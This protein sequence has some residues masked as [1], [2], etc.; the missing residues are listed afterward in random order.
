MGEY[1]EYKGQ[2][3]KLGTCEDLYYT[4]LDQL[5]ELSGVLKT[6]GG[7][8]SIDEYLNPKNGF[9]YRFPFPDEDN[10]GIGDFK[11]FERGLTIQLCAEDYD[12]ADF[13]HYDKWVSCSDN[14]SHN[15]NVKIP[16]PQS[17]EFDKV[18]HSPIDWRIIQIQQVRQIDGELWTIIGCP[19]CK[20]KARI[21]F[22][23]ACKLAHSIEVKYI[24][25]HDATESNKAYYQTI[26]DR[27]L[28]GYKVGVK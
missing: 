17:K 14:G 4:R 12:L 26:I 10:I 22:D 9:R 24:N 23:D 13:E 8:L 25:V 27:M 20:A 19:Y 28:S 3:I 21:G 7:N 6:L 5:K 15:V 16:C 11:E 1:I 2:S 18:K